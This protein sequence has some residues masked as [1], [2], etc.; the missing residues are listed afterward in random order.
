MEPPL[1]LSSSQ[2]GKVTETLLAATL[3]L[4]SGGRL[5]PFVPISDDHG[6]DLI[7]LD[8]QTHRSIAVQVKSAIPNAARGTVAFDVRKATHSEAPGRYLIAVAFAPANVALTA[9][10]LIP[11]SEIANISN[12]T[13]DKYK[14]SANPSPTSND[15]YARYRQVDAKAMA[16]A[17]VAAI[18]A[19]H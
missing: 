10:W 15:R 16:D 13:S 11:L 12:E 8:K 17:V 14:L 7:V 2:K 4:A 5:S 3:I 9:S 1:N 19:N 6:I 18:N